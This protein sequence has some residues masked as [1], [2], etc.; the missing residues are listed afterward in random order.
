MVQGPLMLN[1][2]SA[3]WGLLPRTENGCVQPSQPPSLER[4]KLWL[5]ARV[6]V[7]SRPDWFFVKL[8][9][10]GAPEDQATALLGEPMVKFH[11]GL[12]A[13]ASNDENFQYH[14]VTAREMVNLIRAA[15]TGWQGTVA[16][17]R[18][19]GIHPCS[20]VG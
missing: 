8:H 18:D 19:F 9:A 17:A 14:Y 3:K 7:P 5:R 20:R 2:R 1:W 4:L 16:E 10:H 11:E 15:E 12:A 6:Q 13:L